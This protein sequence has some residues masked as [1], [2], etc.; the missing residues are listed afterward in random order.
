MHRTAA[1]GSGLC[2]AVLLRPLDS[3]VR[4]SPDGSVSEDTLGSREDDAICF[5][6]GED[7]ADD[8]FNS[9]AAFYGSLM[10]LC[11]F[12]DVFSRPPTQ[13]EATGRHFRVA[14]TSSLPLGG[15]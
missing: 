8:D 2:Q 13:A 3:P 10:D 4:F 6:F 5:I 9:A 7:V 15:H 1:P 12:W 14:T 11:V